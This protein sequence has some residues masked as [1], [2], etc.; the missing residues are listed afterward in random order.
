MWCIELIFPN[1]EKKP[2]VVVVKFHVDDSSKYCYDVL[3]V[4]YDADLDITSIF[5]QQLLLANH[6]TAANEN[7]AKL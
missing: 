6:C 1:P 5:F 2:L 3:P 7:I 4:F